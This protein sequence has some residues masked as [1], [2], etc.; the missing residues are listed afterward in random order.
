VRELA[1]SGRTRPMLTEI[2]QLA[3]SMRL[4]TTAKCVESEAIQSAVGQLGVEY[5]QGF[6]VGRPRPLEGVLQELLK[7]AGASRNSESPRRLG[8]LRA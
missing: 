8:R 2:V 3:Q 5:A 7:G 4:R 1:G 6:A